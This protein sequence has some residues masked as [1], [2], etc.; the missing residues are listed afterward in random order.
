MEPKLVV[1]VKGGGGGSYILFMNFTIE[2]MGLCL[3]R[4]VRALMGTRRLWCL[5]VALGATAAGGR[6]WRWR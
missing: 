2:G 4:S 3:Y 6:K 5:I 1:C